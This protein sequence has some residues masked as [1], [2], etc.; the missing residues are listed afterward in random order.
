MTGLLTIRRTGR[1]DLAEVDALFQR[2]YPALLKHHYPPSLMVTAVPLIARAK[3][4]LLTSGRYFAV[5]DA[6]GAIVGAG[7]WSSTDP[8]MGRP[9]AA[10]TGHIRHVVTDHRRTREGV[11][12]ALMAH[13]FGDARAAGIR[14]MDCLSTRMAVPFYAAC[15]FETVRPVVI[16]L[17]E[18]ID[19]PAV[20][21]ERT[22]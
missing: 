13:I 18:A 1:E 2:S 4:E 22:L 10:A 7:G 15:G 9:G 3:P 11:G 16:P 19:F 12:R 8:R 21:M 6:E 14:R 5:V 20:L 17:R